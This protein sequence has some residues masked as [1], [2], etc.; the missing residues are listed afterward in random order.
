MIFSPILG[1][2]LASQLSDKLTHQPEL[3]FEDSELIIASVNFT[4]IALITWD[5]ASGGDE[6]NSTIS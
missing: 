5:T 3:Q 6:A 1:E 2:P 4:N